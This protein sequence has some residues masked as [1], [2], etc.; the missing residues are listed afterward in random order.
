VFVLILIL[1]TYI[2][3]F[4]LKLCFWARQAITV[5]RFC[6]YHKAESKGD[7]VLIFGSVSFMTVKLCLQVF[8]FLLKE[9]EYFFNY[10]F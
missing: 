2:Y 6:P 5:K 4:I 10:I 8:F 3:F 9:K 7:L 1:Y